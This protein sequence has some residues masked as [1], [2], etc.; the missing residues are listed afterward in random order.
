MSDLVLPDRVLDIDVPAELIADRP[1]EA[2]GRRR[3]DVRMLVARRGSGELTHARAIDLPHFL[4]AGDVLV[5]NTSPTLPA[6]VPSADRSVVVHFS[7]DLGG[8]RWVVEVREPCGLGTR[9]HPVDHGQAI[10]LS[11]GAVV[12]LRRPHSPIA[13][14]A[15]R[16]WEADL[17]TPVPLS[18]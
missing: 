11:G 15:A 18:A 14:G 16:L 5:G 10:P 6:A 8:G 1:V 9:P 12:R 2:E 4:T 3:D 7:T 17:I 13:G